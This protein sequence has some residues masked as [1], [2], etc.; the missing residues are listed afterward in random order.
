M[1]DPK[2]FMSSICSSNASDPHDYLDTQNSAE[3]IRRNMHKVMSSRQRQLESDERHRPSPCPQEH[4]SGSD[5]DSLRS[6][7]SSQN[8]NPTVRT[9]HERQV[10]APADTSM[11]KQ[12]NLPTL[13]PKGTE[14]GSANSLTGSAPLNI[15][16]TINNE[17]TSSIVPVPGPIPQPAIAGNGDKLSPRVFAGFNLGLGIPKKNSVPASIPSVPPPRLSKDQ[18]GFLRPKT[19]ASVKPPVPER[20]PI[21]SRANQRTPRV[22]PK[23]SAQMDR[24]KST[25][26]SL[27]QGIYQNNQITA[28]DT[29]YDSDPGNLGNLSSMSA[30]MSLE[31]TLGGANVSNLSVTGVGEQWA[32]TGDQWGK[33]MVDIETPK[34][35]RRFSE[36]FFLFNKVDV[37]LISDFEYFGQFSYR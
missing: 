24:P 22:P 15:S 29:E 3:N 27:N 9:F 33:P 13:P 8:P 16:T 14:T 36:G 30:T 1:P 19:P 34:D 11:L 28:E 37:S 4:L 12:P 20:K 31:T 32:L 35:K 23:Q 2:G 21:H 18:D 10:S 17:R 7:E 26:P 25:P 5:I 6:I